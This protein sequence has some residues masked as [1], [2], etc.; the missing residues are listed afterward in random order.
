MPLKG[1]V[2]VLRLAIN[3]SV[4]SHDV[5]E[6]LLDLRD[7]TERFSLEFGASLIFLACDLFRGLLH[8]RF[9]LAEEVDDFGGDSGLD[10]LLDDF[11]DLAGELILLC[12][13]P[14]VFL[15]PHRT[16]PREVGVGEKEVL[17]QQ[18]KLDDLERGEQRKD[19]FGCS[20]RTFE[21]VIAKWLHLDE[22][23]G[24]HGRRERGS[25]DAVGF[26]VIRYHIV[27]FGCHL[28]E[29]E[30][31]EDLAAAGL[32][33]AV[34]RDRNAEAGLAVDGDLK[35]KLLEAAAGFCG[36]FQGHFLDGGGFRFG[37]WRFPTDRGFGRGRGGRGSRGGFGGRRWPCPRL[38][39]DDEGEKMRYDQG[40]DQHRE[41]ADEAPW[42]SSGCVPE[43]V[44]R[45][46]TLGL[47]D[48]I[49]R[50]SERRHGFQPVFR[51]QGIVEMAGC[52]EE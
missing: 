2:D 10:E 47:G 3:L 5:D 8:H 44:S 14:L 23:H 16:R 28:V 49:I 27:R 4:P 35:R 38:S 46:L 30:G 26:Q 20:S 48:G 18:A 24:R 25:R 51:R 12:G 22:L 37:F 19:I 50:L 9:S 7:E 15:E 40:G 29:I 45:F 32:V 42:G 11:A 41:T 13:H 6:K 21:D 36:C 33:Q 52:F 43:K 1:I 17:L 34:Q 31:G 39:P